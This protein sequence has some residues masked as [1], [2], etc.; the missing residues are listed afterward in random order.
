MI[1]GP[2]NVTSSFSRLLLLWDFVLDLLQYTARNLI[3]IHVKL[4]LD[5]FLY[6]FV[7]PGIGYI[8]YVYVTPSLL[9]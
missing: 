7:T 8:L 1:D 4:E 3:M 2:L 6:V 9:F 5:T